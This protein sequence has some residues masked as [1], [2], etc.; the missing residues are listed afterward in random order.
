MI[1]LLSGYRPND[2]CNLLVE[3]ITSSRIELYHQFRQVALWLHA[4]TNKKYS[5]S[6]D[7]IRMEEEN[8]NDDILYCTIGQ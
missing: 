6:A 5:G 4:T 8:N 2:S 1:N 7:R 3:K